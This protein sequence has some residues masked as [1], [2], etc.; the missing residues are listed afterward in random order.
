[1]L[2]SSARGGPVIQLSLL[3][4]VLGCAFAWSA[5][6]VLRKAL[7]ARISPWALVFLITAGQVPVLALWS[8]VAPLPVFTTGYAAVAGAS[9]LLNLVANLAFVAALQRSPLSLTVPLLSLTPAF[10]AALAIPLLG[11]LPDP[12]QLAGILMVVVGALY[13]GAERAAAPG[14]GGW[15]QALKRE[16]GTPLMLVV[17]VAWS[18]T[19][20]LDKLGVA[21]VGPA[22]HALVLSLGVAGGSLVALVALKGHRSLLPLAPRVLPLLAA[23]MLVGALALALQLVAIRFLLVGVVEAVKRAVGNL[24]ALLLGALLFAEPMSWRKAAALTV[25]ATGVL[26]ILV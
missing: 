16:P 25:M 18:L 12:R 3:A 20:P 26:L 9:I 23:A 14:L 1:V 5:L 11:E 21:A 17:A 15:W 22:W 24:M 6:D 7:A 4:L 2:P 10:T 8:A 19:L 13:L